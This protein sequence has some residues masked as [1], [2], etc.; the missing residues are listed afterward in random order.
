MHLRQIKLR[1]FKH[2]YTKYASK[3]SELFIWLMVNSSSNQLTLYLE[4][5]G[6]RRISYALTLSNVF[7]QEKKCN[8]AVVC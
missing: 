8:A 2:V 6:L 1:N 4:I 3:L 5:K 7:T